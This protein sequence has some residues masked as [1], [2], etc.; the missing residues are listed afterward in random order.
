MEYAEIPAGS[1]T[2]D[3]LAECTATGNAGNGLA[4]GEVSTIVDPVS[5][6]TSAVNQNTTEGGAD[7]RER[8]SLAERV[9][10]AP[11]AYSTAGPEDGYLYHAKESTTPPLVTWWPPATTKRAR[12]ILFSSWPTVPSRARP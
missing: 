11:G 12:W 3:V 9:F 7:V 1:L 8:G 2:V 4:P 6:I 5:Y 10:L